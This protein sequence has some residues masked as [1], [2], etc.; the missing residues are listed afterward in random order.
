VCAIIKHEFAVKGDDMENLARANFEKEI[1]RRRETRDMIQA[2]ADVDEILRRMSAVK[3]GRSKMLTRKE[4]DA[5]LKEL[6]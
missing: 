3:E 4:A 6:D 5:L 2:Q 1:D